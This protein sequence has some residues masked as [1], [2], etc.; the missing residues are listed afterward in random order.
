M[1]IPEKRDQFSE[2]I[3]GRF[4]EIAGNQRFSHL[5]RIQSCTF[6]EIIGNNPHVER[7]FLA[8]ILTDAADIDSIFANAFDWA[9]IAFIRAMIDNDD[10]VSFG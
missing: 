8:D 2:V 10:P 5:H 6:A 1:L 9:D 3:L 7:I 4:I